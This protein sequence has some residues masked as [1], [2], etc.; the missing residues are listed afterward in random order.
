LGEISTLYLV[1]SISHFVDETTG[2]KSNLP[3]GTKPGRD[4]TRVRDSACLYC[5]GFWSLKM[6]LK[7]KRFRDRL[8][9]QIV[10]KRKGTKKLGQIMNCVLT[11]L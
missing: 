2:T 9:R 8:T 11:K 4:K 10:T 3:G 5:V 1:L 7:I 6:N